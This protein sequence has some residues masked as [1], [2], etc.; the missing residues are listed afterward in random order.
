M[1]VKPLDYR[2]HILWM[3]TLTL[4]S[5]WGISQANRTLTILN[6]DRSYA[7]RQAIEL[8]R[9]EQQTELTEAQ[10]EA[11]AAEQQAHIDNNVRLHSSVTLPW[12]VCDPADYPQFDS[13]LYAKA[14]RVN[15][16]DKHGRVIGVI[17]PSGGFA[18]QPEK[19]QA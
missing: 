19:C 2:P 4:M 15:V 14:E 11:K 17:E 9:I 12:Y 5:A 10:I 18:F 16:S 8:T 1:R 6:R 3:A 13:S 7:D